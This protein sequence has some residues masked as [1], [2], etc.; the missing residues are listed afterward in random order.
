M[1]TTIPGESLRARSH[2]LYFPVVIHLSVGRRIHHR[3][4]DVDP[5]FLIHIN[6]GRMAL[7]A[8]DPAG[9][10]AAAE[11]YPHPGE[12]S[13]P[14]PKLHREGQDGERR[15]DDDEYC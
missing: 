14:R 11:A 3:Q 1:V 2:L 5:L 8:A 7:P 6:E 13:E 15:L 4:A 9:A 12:V 10:A